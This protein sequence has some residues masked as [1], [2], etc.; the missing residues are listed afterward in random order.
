MSV[1]KKKKKWLPECWPLIRVCETLAVLHNA[2]FVHPVGQLWCVPEVVV[3]PVMLQSAKPSHCLKGA[4][5]KR[6]SNN[7]EW[8]WSTN[9][10]GCTWTLKW[11]M[12]LRIKITAALARWSDS[13]KNKDQ[14]SHCRWLHDK[15]WRASF[16][17]P[18]SWYVTKRMV[19]LSV[20]FILPHTQIILHAYP[21]LWV[22]RRSVASDVR[23]GW[24]H[25]LWGSLT[26]QTALFI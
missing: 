4:F 2:W 15:R 5:P 20:M 12:H 25:A 22:M 23:A 11:A 21:Q 10:K 9:R 24:C 14:I 17:M 13:H 16:L 18:P 7:W 19:M 6:V 3:F 8:E 1:K 26:Y